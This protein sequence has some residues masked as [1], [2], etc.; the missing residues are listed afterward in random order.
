MRTLRASRLFRRAYPADVAAGIDRKRALPVAMAGVVVVA[1]IVLGAFV[2]RSPEPAAPPKSAAPLKGAP[3]LVLDLPAKPT[4]G[5]AALA[6]V[7]ADMRA[8]RAAQ[9]ETSLSRARRLLGAGDL[10]VQVAGALLR[11]RPGEEDTAIGVLRALASNDDR[12]PVPA[13]HLGLALLWSGQ[14]SD[15]TAELQQTRLINPD[16]IY[17]RTAD[18]VLHPTYRKD[19]PIWLSSQ[20]VKGSLAQLRAKAA[21]APRSLRAQLDYAYALQFVSRT[22]ARVIAERALA[23][24]ATNIDAQ[25]AVIVLGFD[26]D[27]PAQAVGRLARLMQSRAEAPSPRFHFGELLSW[28]GQDAK[29]KEQ[30]RQASKLDPDGIMGRFARS[31]LAASK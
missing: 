17:G 19:Y 5:L 25:V 20:A 6:K 27:V 22:R 18:D 24:D 16:G 11:Y 29:A 10:R 7:A 31:V 14:R 2:M 12:A 23:L 4:G 26:K 30:Y 13:L 21:A 8:G 3:P 15:A 1:V 28:I 9:A